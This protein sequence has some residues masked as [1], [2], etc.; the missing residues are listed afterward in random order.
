MGLLM[1]ACYVSTDYDRYPEGKLVA[2]A[3]LVREWTGEGAELSLRG[4][5]TFS[6]SALLLEYFSCSSSGVQRKSGQGTWDTIEDRGVTS[7]LIRFGDGCSAS[8]WTGMSE[9]KTVL[10][11][12]QA[13]ESELLILR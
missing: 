13:G 9:G 2:D 10:W 12:T 5:A 11:A 1:S 8:M 4:D 3:E 7:V 6:A